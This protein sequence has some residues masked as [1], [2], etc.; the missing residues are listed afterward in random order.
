MRAMRS[1]ELAMSTIVRA[2][3]SVLWTAFRLLAGFLR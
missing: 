1:A 2:G 3:D